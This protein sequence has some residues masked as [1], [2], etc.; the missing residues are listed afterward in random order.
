M[1]QLEQGVH[2]KDNKLVQQLETL[3]GVWLT[4]DS[5]RIGDSKP[6]KG[7]KAAVPVKAVVKEGKEAVEREDDAGEKGVPANEVLATEI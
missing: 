6:R 3:L 2:K 5:D 7:K 1:V 4:G